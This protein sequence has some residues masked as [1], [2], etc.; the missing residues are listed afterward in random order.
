MNVTFVAVPKDHCAF[1]KTTR[2]SCLMSDAPSTVPDSQL[3]EL[4]IMVRSKEKEG[5]E[6]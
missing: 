5:G 3:A 4:G 6:R 2:A 1:P